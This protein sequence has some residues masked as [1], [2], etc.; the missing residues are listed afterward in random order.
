MTLPT[1]ADLL[2]R[3][4]GRPERLLLLAAALLVAD[5]TS[6]QSTP[7]GWLLA[8]VSML[9]AW[10]LTTAVVVRRV[11][12]GLKGWFGRNYP[13]LSIALLAPMPIFATAAVGE[14]V[15]ALS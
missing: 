5:A 14:M 8:A 15:R 6:F 2:L 11:D 4:F 10:A 3:A 7:F 1:P 12:R 9:A 13:R